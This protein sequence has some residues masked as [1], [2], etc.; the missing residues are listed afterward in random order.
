ML[1]I[2]GVFD[3]RQI[4]VLN[5]LIWVARL[6]GYQAVELISLQNV[7]VLVLQKYFIGTDAK[8][9]DSRLLQDPDAHLFYVKIV[10]RFHVEAIHLGQ[11]LEP[12]QKYSK[13]KLDGIVEL[14]HASIL[15][16][17]SVSHLSDG[18][19][20]HK[21]VGE[22]V[23]VGF[24]ALYKDRLSVFDYRNDLVEGHVKVDEIDRV[25]VVLVDVAYARIFATLQ[26]SLSDLVAQTLFARLVLRFGCER[27]EGNVGGTSPNIRIATSW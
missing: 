23:L 19:G 26:I 22:R 27:F 9:S 25:Q 8:V 12:A 1:K 15:D 16:Q 14:A 13:V 24:Y 4:F 10:G 18:D 20:G 5:K 3:S 17:T 7:Q 21:L 2:V 6:V 11:V